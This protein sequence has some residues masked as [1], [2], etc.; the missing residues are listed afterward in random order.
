V[1]EKR[2]F[3]KEKA[4]TGANVI[5]FKQKTMPKTGEKNLSKKIYP[6]KCQDVDRERKTKELLEFL[7]AF[8]I[9]ILMAFLYHRIWI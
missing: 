4:E 1:E 6:I 8:G 7:G 3:A 5:E 9:L 2:N